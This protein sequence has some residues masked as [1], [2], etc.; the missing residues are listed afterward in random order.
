MADQSP[1]QN[2]DDANRWLKVPVS[3]LT[4]PKPGRMCHGPR[5]WAVIDDG[6]VKCALFFQSG[7]RGR[8]KQ[9]G[10]P[11]C[12]ESKHILERL[13]PDCETVFIEMTFIP[14]N[15]WEYED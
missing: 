13:R 14:H 12:S 4:T 15:Q 6:G 8:G 3:E 9:Y 5:W 2:Y 1:Y 10:S 11:Q 7:S